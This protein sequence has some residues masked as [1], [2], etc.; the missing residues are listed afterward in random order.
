M[1]HR[2]KEEK[3]ASARTYYQTHNEEQRAY[4]QA[5]YQAHKEEVKAY[6]RAYHQAHREERKAS[7]RAYRQAHQEEARAYRQAHKEERKASKRAA[8]AR[9]RGASVG[10]VA[11]AFIKR[12]D[13][14]ICGI[15]GKKVRP[16]NLSFDHIIP[17]SKGGPHATWNLQVAH[18]SC[19]SARGPGRTPGKL[20]LDF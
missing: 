3:K 5:Y 18:H 2:N 20:R 9:K 4:R 17:L 12:R 15:C 11:F 1:P 8:K 10:P 13:R 6:A 14:M 16:Q 7:K 19:N